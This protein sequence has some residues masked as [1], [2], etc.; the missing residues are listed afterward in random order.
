MPIQNLAGFAQYR[1]TAAAVLTGANTDY[2]TPSNAALLTVAGPDGSLVTRLAATPRA[3]ITA[4]QLQVFLSKD[5]GAT[6]SLLGTGLL[7]A[8][9]VATS[10][11]LSTLAMTQV[12]GSQISETNPIPLSGVTDFGTTAPTFVGVT[13]G[14]AN[15]QVLPFSSLTTNAARTIIDFEAG[16]TNTL[17]MTLAV[18]TATALSV[19]WDNSAAALAAGDITAGFR[20]RAWTDGAFWRLFRTDRLYVAA[21]LALAG[22]IVVTAQQADF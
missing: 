3:T 20:Y 2:E 17:T 5:A 15:A 9:T 22:G 14:S 10:T 12:D 21:G 18:G 7:P 19:V 16:L 6:F 8:Q 11:Q 13:Q 1:R 4:T